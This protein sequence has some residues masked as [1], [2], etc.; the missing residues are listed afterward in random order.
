MLFQTAK[1][2]AVSEFQRDACGCIV[3]SLLANMKSKN[4]LGQQAV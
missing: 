2:D 4:Q 1:G 3:P